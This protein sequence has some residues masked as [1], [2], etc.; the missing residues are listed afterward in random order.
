[1]TLEQFIE[2]IYSEMKEQMEDKNIIIQPVL[3]NNGNVYH[4]L[5]IHDSVHNLSPTIYIEPYYYQYQNGTAFEDIIANMMETYLENVPT[6]DFDISNFKDFKKAQTRIVMKLVNTEQN[7]ALLKDIP[8]R[9]FLDLSIIYSVVVC[10]FMGEFGSILIHNQHMEYWGITEEELY[11]IAQENTPK[12]LPHSLT[13]IKIIL[14]KVDNSISQYWECNNMYVLTNQLRI[15]GAA[16]IVY[17]KL[18]R[19]IS[20]YLEDNLII[21]PSSVHEVMII[22]KQRLENVYSMKELNSI[23]REVNE[24]ELRNDEVLSNHVYYFDG[25]ELQIAD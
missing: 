8:H 19:K 10:D 22:P 3:K 11:E 15:N 6:K 21:I 16:C 2:L 23:V 24:T 7:K 20:D 9:A 4:G 25:T 1:M 13:D 5:I 14:D 18:L 12:L 17:P